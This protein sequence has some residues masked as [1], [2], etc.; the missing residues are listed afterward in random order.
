MAKSQHETAAAIL[1]AALFAAEK[2]RNCRRKGP[3][4]TPYIN[5]PITVA[6]TLATVGEVDDIEV[7]QAA[8]LHDTVED[9]KTT[10]E[11]LEATFGRGVRDLVMEV[12]DD[13]NLKKQE[14]KRRQI[15]KAPHLSPRAKMIKIAD[16]IANVTDIMEAP[17]ADWSRERQAQYV[18]WSR[19]VVAG[20]VG[21]NEALDRF[22]EEIAEKATSRLRQ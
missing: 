5:H 21:Q 16:K 20:C 10:P 22:Y 6:R 9:T 12:T 11:E 3:D 13:K 1:E 17:P 14:R 8:L 19:N 4:A 7:L 15:E 2:H 18:K